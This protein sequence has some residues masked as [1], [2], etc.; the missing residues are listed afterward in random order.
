MH[1]AETS[2]YAPYIRCMKHGHPHLSDTSDDIGIEI[3]LIAVCIA[4][5]I[6]A[7]AYLA[8]V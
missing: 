6:S 2:V 7:L 5:G 8:I 4:I 3:A 1:V